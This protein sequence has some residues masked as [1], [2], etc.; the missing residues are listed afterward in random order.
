MKNVCQ[1]LGELTVDTIMSASSPAASVFFMLS[2]AV[3]HVLVLSESVVDSHVS[4]ED[5]KLTAI[6]KL[7]QFCSI[8]VTCVFWKR[9]GAGGPFC[10]VSLS[11]EVKEATRGV[12]V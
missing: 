3:S 4:Q 6:S 9:L 8:H 12:N 11:G 10:L 5:P 7:G 1:A 2:S